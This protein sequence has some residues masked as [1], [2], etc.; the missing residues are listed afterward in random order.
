MSVTQA[1]RNDWPS[2]LGYQASSAVTGRWL[3]EPCP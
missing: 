3:A 1:R 2:A